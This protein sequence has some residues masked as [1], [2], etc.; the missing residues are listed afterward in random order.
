VLRGDQL[1]LD[2]LT[3]PVSSTAN[4]LRGEMILAI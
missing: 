3:I 4:G 2:K 1:S